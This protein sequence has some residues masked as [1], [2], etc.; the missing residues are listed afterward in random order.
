MKNFPIKIDGIEYWIS[1]SVA[2]AAFIFTK[3]KNNNLCVLA[4]KRGS[5]TPD[6]QGYYNC[7]CGYLDYDETTIQA[8]HREVFE[9][10]GV[11][12]PKFMSIFSVDSNPRSNK[13]NVTLNYYGKVEDP[14]QTLPSG[15]EINEVSEVRWINV[16]TLDRY[17]WAFSHDKI[18]SKIVSEIFQ[19]D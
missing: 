13:Q 1:R 17:Q 3:D 6:F 4:N 14:I 7:P 16:N 10:T 9:E 19:N 8:V 15:G 5:G 18:I 11:V 2:V 12:C